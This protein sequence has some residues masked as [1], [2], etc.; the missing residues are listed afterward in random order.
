MSTEAIFIL[1][2]FS[3]LGLMILD[4]MFTNWCDLKT[5]KRILDKKDDK[6]DE[7]IK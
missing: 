5:N 4:N 3:L 2:F 1:C 7:N 6:K